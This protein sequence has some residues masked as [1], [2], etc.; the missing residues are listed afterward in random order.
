MSQRDAL[1]HW[2]PELLENALYGTPFETLL[3][4][5]MT[6][7]D[8]RAGRNYQ[9]ASRALEGLDEFQNP[10]LQAEYCARQAARFFEYKRILDETRTRIQAV[11]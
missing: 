7:C 4:G 3:T 10:Q 9:R 1:R 6:W 2:L 11:R 5:A 8:R